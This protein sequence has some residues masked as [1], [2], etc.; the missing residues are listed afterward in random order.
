[1]LDPDAIRNVMREI[2]RTLVPYATALATAAAVRQLAGNI[3]IMPSKVQGRDRD[4]LVSMLLEK[5]TS[6]IDRVSSALAHD[7]VRDAALAYAETL[8]KSLGA[9]DERWKSDIPGRP[10]LHQ[11]AAKVHLHQGRA[12]RL[13]LGE[14]AKGDH[15]PFEEVIEIFDSFAH[16]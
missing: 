6:E 11:F 9:D 13:Y 5:S 15:S 16:H 3:D 2:A 4:V 8:E 14:S 12:K 10:L 7:T 1:M